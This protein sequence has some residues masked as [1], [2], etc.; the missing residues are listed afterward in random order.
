MIRRVHIV[1]TPAMPV[2][3]VHMSEVRRNVN[4]MVQ[5]SKTIQLTK[6]IQLL[7]LCANLHILVGRSI[8][9]VIL[10]ND[11][12][13]SLIFYSTMRRPTILLRIDDFFSLTQNVIYYW[14]GLFAPSRGPQGK[15]S[16]LDNP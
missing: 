6:N 11:L 7:V 4:I 14:P 15:K 16:V 1:G 13:L 2:V 9:F 12:E 8:C 5:R 10:I 3:E